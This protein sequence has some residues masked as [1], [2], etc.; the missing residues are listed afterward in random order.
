MAT[1]SGNKH[2]LE[3]EVVEQNKKQKIVTKKGKQSNKYFYNQVTVVII[4]KQPYSVRLNL[5]KPI[6]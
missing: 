2:Q 6:Y 5:S 1:V 4:A 3:N